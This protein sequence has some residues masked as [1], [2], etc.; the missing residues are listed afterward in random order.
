MNVVG[1]ETD[2]QE[3]LELCD[4]KSTYFFFVYTQTLDLNLSLLCVYLG[5]AKRFV[6][7]IFR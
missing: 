7:E 2:L 5:H 4:F 3:R 1:L 6:T